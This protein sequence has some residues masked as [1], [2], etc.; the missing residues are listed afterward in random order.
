MSIAK[1]ECLYDNFCETIRDTFGI[2]DNIIIQ[3][4]RTNTLADFARLR[5]EERAAAMMR[6]WLTNFKSENPL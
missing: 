4:P 3:T 5:Q 1:G 2:P 6:E